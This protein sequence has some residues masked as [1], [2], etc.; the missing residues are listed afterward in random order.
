MNLA[1]LLHS[2]ITVLLIAFCSLLFFCGMLALGGVI[3]LTAFASYICAMLVIFCVSV[4]H[5]YKN[6]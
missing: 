2:V 5:T 3:G 1:K 6:Y 4:F